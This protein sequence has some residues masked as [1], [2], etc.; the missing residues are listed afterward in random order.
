M[1]AINPNVLRERVSGAIQAELDLAEWER[2]V[3]AE[4]VER[5]SIARA[6]ATW[7]SCS[8]LARE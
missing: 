8:G 2:Y 1:D 7:N 3:S 6:L 5:E 4:H